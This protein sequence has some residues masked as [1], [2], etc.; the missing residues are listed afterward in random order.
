MLNFDPRIDEEKHE[1][2]A[3]G[4]GDFE[5]LKSELKQSKAGNAYISL[6]LKVWDK[7]GRQGTVFDYLMSYA[8]KHKLKNFCYATGL[9]HN[10]DQGYLEPENCMG[11]SGKLILGI[12]K[13]EKG[14]YK[15]KN[16]VMDYICSENKPSKDDK[17]EEL[18]PL[19]DD[20]PF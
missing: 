1:L 4:E 19:D 17:K 15:D 8:M 6:I 11:K 10:Y 13:D 20:I 5:V 9:N 12:E 7:N 14:V 18:N 3:P 2:L 16:R